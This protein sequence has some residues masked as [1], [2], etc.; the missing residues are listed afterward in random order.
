MADVKKEKSKTMNV[1]IF[2][3]DLYQKVR[4]LVKIAI[5]N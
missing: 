5:R 1:Y 4:I 2:H 3:Y